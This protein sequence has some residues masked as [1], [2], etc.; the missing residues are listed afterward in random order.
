MREMNAHGISFMLIEEYA[1]IERTY[2]LEQ[3]NEDYHSILN[4]DSFIAA[5]EKNPWDFNEYE[6]L[7]ESESIF[8]Y[9]KRKFTAEISTDNGSFEK[10]FSDYENAENWLEEQKDKYEDELIDYEISY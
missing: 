5:L 2:N 9:S 10:E 6:I 7:E 4:I 3:I 1:I 8:D